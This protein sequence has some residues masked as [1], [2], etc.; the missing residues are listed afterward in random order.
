MAIK[1][2]YENL[3]KQKLENGINLF[4]GAGFSVL[5][6]DDNQKLPDASQLCGEIYKTFEVDNSFGDDLESLSSIIESTASQQYQSFLRERFKIDKY[7]VLYDTIN[8]INMKSY[9]TTN[10]DNIIE[11]VIDNSEKYYFRSITQYGSPKF[12]PCEV[13]Y[14]PLHGNVSDIESHLYFGKFDL[15]MVDD[16][17]KDLF[18][19]A[20]AHLEKYPTLFWGYGFHD[21]GV[22]KIVT[23]ILKKQ[24]K[25][26][27]VQCREE[28]SM[29]SLYKALGCHIIVGET[30]ELLEW[31]DQNIT[32]SN[33]NQAL[34][35]K[36]LDEYKLPTINK[37]AVIPREEYYT[38]SSTNWYNIIS[39]HAYSRPIISK[40]ED[41]CIK[42]KNVIIDGISFSGKTTLLMQ[43]ALKIDAPI[44]LYFNE[45]TPNLSKFIINTIGSRNKAFIFVDEC[46]N[47]MDAYAIL[48][49]ATN[50]YTIST[51]E[52]FLFESSKH[53]L[54]HILYKKIDLD[55]LNRTEAQAIYEKIPQ[56]VRADNFHYKDN[57]EEKF[58]MFEMISKNVANLLSEDKVE[59]ILQNVYTENYKV[60]EIVAV[61][62][63]LN[64]NKSVSSL[65]IFLSYF[66][67]DYSIICKYIE[68][69]N[70]LLSDTIVIENE[71]NEAYY[72]LRSNL[73]TK[74]S[75]STLSSKFK[76]DY[77]KIVKRFIFQVNPFK[78][79]RYDVFKRSAYDAT[80]FYKLYGNDANDI[81]SFIYNYDNNA[82]TLQQW[83]L[84]KTKT[85][86]FKGAFDDIDNALAVKPQNFSIQNTHAI[87]LFEANKNLRTAE[88]QKELTRAMDILSKCYNSDKR[89]IYHAQK[90][91][92]FAIFLANN[93][94]NSSYIMS[95]NEWI[96]NIITYDES[97][98]PWT[99]SLQRKLKQMSQ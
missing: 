58:G 21:S 3:F 13:E 70:M 34:G 48:A 17:N 64:Y 84:Y 76:N 67:E 46:S 85:G 90:Y 47:D 19:L 65:D 18:D 86:D 8:K 72:S 28:G 74:Y 52:T 7:N 6:D 71:D 27:W 11:S 83:A 41:L 81:Y 69:A 15:A 96:E 12:A 77:K 91:A 20:F 23:R 62:T 33:S 68:D 14:L 80:F 42:Y 38:N 43:L 66:D 54:D 36:L 94:S 56:K 92:E 60:F 73:F 49:R 50:I 4:T 2:E 89:K 55:E 63:Y 16:Y 99:L 45:L 1:I 35:N 79:H 29:S 40:I 5:P 32:I 57:L 93:F 39:F 82:Y 9:I 53:K 26:I 44:K 88:A 25:D 24:Q 31:I 10:I 75:N 59:H 61:T 30:Q 37:V 95:A 97:R 51:S 22:N 98:S 87:I 78:I